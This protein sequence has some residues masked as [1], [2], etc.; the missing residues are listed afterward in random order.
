MS[1]TYVQEISAITR[2]TYCVLSAFTL[3]SFE[4]AI[5]VDREARLVWRRKITGATVLFLL[6][7]YWLFLEYITQ[8]ISMYPLSDRGYVTHTVVQDGMACWMVI[9]GNAGPPY[10]WAV[11]SALRA[12]AL[13]KHKWWVLP[14]TFVWFVPH[15]VMESL[16]YS[17]LK[18]FEAPPPFNCVLTSSTSESE[19]VH[20]LGIRKVAAGVQVKTSLTDALFKDGTLYFVPQR[21]STPTLSLRHAHGH[22]QN[23]SAVTAFQ[24][25]ITSIL[26]SR[27]ILNLRDV[28]EGKSDDTT[29]PSFVRHSRTGTLN[30][31]E[32]VD[33]M[34]TGLNHGAHSESARSSMEW[35]DD[36]PEESELESFGATRMYPGSRTDETT[37]RLPGSPLSTEGP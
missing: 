22:L 2:E 4:W 32:F 29:D 11:F 24:D 36:G 28:V 31:A 34:G 23:T 5:T 27:F 17:R 18:P 8:V 14:L 1:E 6:N 19:W 26:I 20:T 3:L 16:Y 10:I 13:S 7:R 30:F 33:S 37:L 15:V 9:I 12:Y 25:P 21:F 35:S